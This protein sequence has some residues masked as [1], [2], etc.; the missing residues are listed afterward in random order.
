[1]RKIILLL[2]CSSFSMNNIYSNYNERLGEVS[3]EYIRKLLPENPI[4]VEAGAHNGTDTLEMAKLWP[5][6]KIHAFEPIPKLFSELKRKTL[7]C[8]NVTCYDYA[9]SNSNGI[10]NFFVS[11]G[12]EDG[13]S[14]ILKPSGNL[15]VHHPQILFKEMIN[16]ES[17]I[18]DEWAKK[19]H[20]DHVDFLW[21]DLQGAEYLILE[22]SPK[23]LESVKVIYSEISLVELYE[24]TLLYPQYRKWLEEK[25]FI[26]IREEI[27]WKDGGNVLFVKKDLLQ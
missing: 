26:V 2:I 16:V 11:S 20:I 10:Q 21:F 6:G 17:I 27:P 12:G 24:G 1:M 13:S 9:L 23:V 18:L 19:H 5:N 14:S 25:G 8:S 4:I 15:T 3:K 22:A 7:N